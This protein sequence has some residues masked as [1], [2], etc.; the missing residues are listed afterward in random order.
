MKRLRFL[1]FVIIFLNGCA[2]L[3][4]PTSRPGF[5]MTTSMV[6][7]QEIYP[8]PDD[9]GRINFEDEIIKIKFGGDE[10]QINFNLTNKTSEPIKI[11]WD[12][13]A[14]IDIFR[15]SHR[16]MHKGVRFVERDRVQPPT[17]VAPDTGIDDL[18]IP[19]DN[20]VSVT[21]DTH[22]IFSQSTINLVP[23]GDGLGWMAMPLFPSYGEGKDE[24]LY[25]GKQFGILLA[26]DTGNK[27]KNYLFK[28]KIDDVFAPRYS[29][30]KE[31]E[32]SLGIMVHAVNDGILVLG[33]EAD[34]SASKADIKKGDKILEING[35]VVNS[36][37][38]VKQ[39]LQA[40]KVGEKYD[41]LI[42]RNN[43]IKTISVVAEGY[44]SQQ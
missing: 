23:V 38:T 19:V 39:A 27:T 29:T 30:R 24:E 43:E 26:L 2:T 22:Y 36:M 12:N 7:P 18:I 32:V 35:K 14:Y 28:F 44:K 17:T 13:S 41:V 42:L 3:G 1:L 15:T 11:L 31:G 34:T 25:K 20:V 40:I 8:S 37:K 21:S 16:V 9:K 5:Y 10:K 4:P 6:E 33:V